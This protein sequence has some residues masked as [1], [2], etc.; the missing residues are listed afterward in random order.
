MNHFTAELNSYKMSKGID[1]DGVDVL[2]CLDART[3]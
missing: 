3:I 1:E 2:T